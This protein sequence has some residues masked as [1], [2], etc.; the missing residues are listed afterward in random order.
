VADA[1]DDTVLSFNY[2]ARVIEGETRAVLVARPMVEIRLDSE[3]LAG[4]RRGDFVSRVDLEILQALTE[5]DQEV[6]LVVFDAQSPEG[7]GRWGFDPELDDEERMELGHHLLRSQLT[8]YRRLLEMNVGGLV[9]VGFGTIALAVFQRSA[10]RIVTELSRELE[11]ASPQRAAQIEIDLWLVE[12]AATWTG[13]T[14]EEYF[15]TKL[16]DEIVSRERKR[17]EIE[18]L[19]ARARSVHP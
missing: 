10:V 18:T 17:P 11:S 8:L 19:L 16:N 12:H 4:M 15:A 5:R 6:A 9:G 13:L 3:R 14:L 1:A 7:D 2:R